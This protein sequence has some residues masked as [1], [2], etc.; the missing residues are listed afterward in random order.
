MENESQ[1]LYRIVIDAYCK[2]FHANKRSVNGLSKI[3]VWNR[4]RFARE[5]EKIFCVHYNNPDN[6][7][8]INAFV[9][10]LKKYEH[11]RRIPEIEEEVRAILKL[12][13]H[14]KEW[15]EDE[16]IFEYVYEPLRTTCFDILKAEIERRF[17]IFYGSVGWTFFSKPFTFHELVEWIC[18]HERQHL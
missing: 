7:G 9:E 16:I 17:G 13:F 6:L 8:N 3:S 5:L 15:R 1:R 10:Y 4:G 2:L 11:T 14:N 12:F 18:L